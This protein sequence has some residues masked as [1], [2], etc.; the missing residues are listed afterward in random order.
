M[1]DT[2]PRL[3]SATLVR[4]RK[5]R[6]P[7]Y[8]RALVTPGIVHLGIGNF[9][10]AHQAVYVDDGLA[11]DPSWGIIGV[12]LRSPDMRNALVPQD[13][14]Y[15]LAVRDAGTTSAR[16]I[17]SVLGILCPGGATD[18]LI[19][20]MADPAIRIVSLTVT[21]K[22][23][24]HDP[25]TGN[26]DA[27]R[28]D[29]RADAATPAAPRTVPGILVAALAA[30]R[31]RGVAPFTVLSC[32][33]L[34]ANGHT[35]GR[36]TAQMAALT[37]DSL[38]A[39]IER[40]VAFPSTMIDRIVPATID[41]DRAEITA[42]T[43]V[44][45]AWPVMTEPFTQWVIEDR[46]TSGRPP[47]PGAEV[48]GDAEPYEKMKLRMLNGAHSTLAYLGQLAGHETVAD[49][50]ADSALA[51]LVDAMWRHEIIPTLRVPGADV[52]A[53]ATAL[54]ERFR[55]P[56]LRHR[57]AQI[58]MDGSQKVPQRLLDTI[59]DRRAAGQPHP[60]L[61]LGVAAWLAYVGD[62]RFTV[63]DPMAGRFAA[64]AKRLPD[65]AAYTNAML[66]M[67]DVFGDL[68]RD[69]AF[70]HALADAVATLRRD[71]VR[72]SLREVA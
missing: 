67:G 25:A 11:T 68:A 30:R 50:M 64:A 65:V 38:A 52:A 31:A 70:R 71:G 24:C 22:G 53:Y 33:N 17:A 21:E 16:V 58:A 28:A 54:A 5:A 15:T 39:W 19:E 8:D 3:S 18:A 66:G 34:P 29:I 40:E 41:A 55:N 63:N 1:S 62:G 44:K 26:L 35:L 47:L 72:K 32:D 46:F 6:L 48:V 36:I 37:D 45:D 61:T 51:A 4:M 60:R 56:A 69:D 9:H 49:A 43:G 13:A 23:Y 20:R 57:T 42:L 12:S 14:L 10:R 27:H 2:C 59:R 7:Q